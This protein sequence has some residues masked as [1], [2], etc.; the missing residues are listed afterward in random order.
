MTVDPLRRAVIA[1]AAAQGVLFAVLGLA[2][3]ATFHNETFDL[4]FY[5]RIAWGFA[6][7]DFW[8]PMVNAH[9]YGLHISPVLA[10]FGVFG[11]AAAPLLIVAQAAALAAATVPLARIGVR[12]L[13][14]NGALIG[15]V[16]WLFHPNLGHVAGYEV[17]PGAMAALPLAWLA[18]SIDRG[19]SR[20]FTF[21][22]LGV[23]ACREDLALVTAAAA[24]LFFLRHR[25]RWRPALGAFAGSVVYALLFLLVLHPSYA[26]E[27]GSLELHFGRFGDSTLEVAVYLLTHPLEL[28]A[29][30]ATPARL[31]YLPR[32]LAPLALLT[33]LRP[34]WL[35]PALPVLAINLI[36]DWPT[37]TSLE[38]Q[39]L[40]PALPF[41]VAGAVEGAARFPSSRIG[42][43][44]VG[45]SLVGHLVA[46]GSPLSLR[47][48]PSAFR[49]DVDTAAAR[50]IVG[51]IPP[52]V[53]VQAPDPL[54]SHLA[55]RSKIRRVTSPEAGYDFLVLDV[56]HRRRFA[57]DEDVLRT[58]E[59]PE[60]RTWLARDDHRVLVGAGRYL[61]LERGHSPR[62][63]QGGAAIVGRAD[64]TAGTSIAACLG[65]LGARLEG[66]RLALDLVARGP[67][68]SDLA[69]RLGTG[70]RPRR[71]DLL[72]AGWLSPAQ[73]RAGDRLRSVHRLGPDE[74]RR[75]E[76]RGLRIGALR[77]SGARPEHADPTAVDVPLR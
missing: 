29:H 44:L 19:H 46:G 16:A 1:L 66:D 4:A 18:W 5:T 12:H 76:R 26:P 9:F 74:R 53:S 32:V 24:L 20:A 51:A 50:A 69:V 35:L 59:E 45:A 6:H 57:A 14:P 64:P 2:R 67:C 43:V 70:W 28:A 39:Y 10:P 56:A 11:A 17:H 8:E 40:T 22:T 37:T 61:L 58:V 13:G 3:W 47:Y 71:V 55:A 27:T 75:I 33:L 41:L 31:T 62:E 15:A 38:V 73:F 25:S 23:L 30:L 36:S 54:L 77:S 63:G 68:P 48:D 21:A 60:V 7:A 49:P 42:I 52:A 72:F 65:V 34:S